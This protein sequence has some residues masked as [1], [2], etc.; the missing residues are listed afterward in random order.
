MIRLRS[1]E[2][3][4]TNVASFPGIDVGDKNKPLI[5]KDFPGYVG[6]VPGVMTTPE[7]NWACQPADCEG[8]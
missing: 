3:V 4:P 7:S 2:P 6:G 1:T 8:G 5:D